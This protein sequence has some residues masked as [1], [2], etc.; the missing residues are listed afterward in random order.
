MSGQTAS[1]EVYLNRVQLLLEITQKEKEL[2]FLAKYLDRCPSL[3]TVCDEIEASRDSLHRQLDAID[4]S[5]RAQAIAVL[6]KWRGSEDE[7]KQLVARVF[8]DMHHTNFRLPAQCD[9]YRSE[10]LSLRGTVDR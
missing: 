7:E 1:H 10:I 9:A 5:E 3:R 6:D 2:R 4:D 8:R